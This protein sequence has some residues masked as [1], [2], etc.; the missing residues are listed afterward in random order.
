MPRVCRKFGPMSPPTCPAAPVIVAHALC[1]LAVSV[2]LGGCGSR[3]DASSVPTV[4]TLAEDPILLSRV[5]ERCNADP[6]AVATAE[7]INA[8]AAS[9]RRSADREAAR[10]QQAEAS[11]ERAREARRRADEA[12]AR[13][14]NEGTTRRADAYELPVEGADSPPPGR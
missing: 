10:A 4:A 3:K 8:R 11:F 2:A 5:L 13:R 14:A 12:A 6:S 7:C 9:D 1:V